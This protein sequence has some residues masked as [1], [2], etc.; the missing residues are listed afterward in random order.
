MNVPAWTQQYGLHEKFDFIETH[1]TGTYDHYG[2][3]RPFDDVTHV[4]RKSAFSLRPEK[5][6]SGPRKFIPGTR[7]LAPK[8]YRR[9]AVRVT[10][11][12]PY[13]RVNSAWNGYGTRTNEYFLEGDI[14]PRMPA[15]ADARGQDLLAK[16]ETKAL[17]NLRK[18]RVELGVDAFE[19][20]KSLNMIAAPI[21]ALAR[22]ILALKR[23][24]FWEIPGLLGLNRRDL[25]TGKTAADLWLQYQYGWKP[26]MSTAYAGV[27]HLRDGLRSGLPVYW[28]KGYA[29][30]S[31][32]KVDSY[33]G[34]GSIDYTWDLTCRSKIYYVVSNATA[35]MVDSLGLSNPLSVAWELVPFSFV[36]DWFVPVGNL[37][38]ALTATAGLEF[39][40]GYQ[41]TLY[42]GHQ[43]IVFAKYPPNPD[44]YVVD[45]AGAFRSEETYMIRRAYGNFPSPRLYAEAHPFS[46]SHVLSALALVRQLF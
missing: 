3:W 46:T 28:A 37:F 45:K 2:E 13:R 14:F 30:D 38:S 10:D 4:L 19:A 26:L 35:D 24:R 29:R 18:G 41:T 5:G 8:D 9:R 25:L 31:V 32:N 34:T 7:T 23:G 20:R 15:D 36:V 6:S 33:G 17:L 27:Q 16:A 11:D 42:N 40:A 21:S 1:K 39:R 44:N 43:N 12:I 22:S